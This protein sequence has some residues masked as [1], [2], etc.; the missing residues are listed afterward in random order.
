MTGVLKA[1][2]LEAV[3]AV[4]R[5]A[6]RHVRRVVLA[7]S[8]IRARPAS[9]PVLIRADRVRSILRV[10]DLPALAPAVRAALV[11]V[12]VLAHGRD[13]ALRVP[14]DLAQVP[15]D[16]RLRAKLRALRVLRDRRVAVDASSIPRPKKAR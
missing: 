15:A 4:V 3:S 14:V 9:S 6:L 1:A 12:L 2:V 10:R 11:R 5:A 8:R 7:A 13:L 16:R